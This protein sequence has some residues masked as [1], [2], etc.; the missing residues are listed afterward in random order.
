M[1]MGLLDEIREYNKEYTEKTG[2]QPP[3]SEGEALMFVVACSLF[4]SIALEM[5]P[6]PKENDD[7]L[8]K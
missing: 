5:F 8:K 2:L 1:I 3:V 4:P 7:T 6:K